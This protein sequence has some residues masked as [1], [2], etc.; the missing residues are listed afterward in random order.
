MKKIKN[1]MLTG[2]LLMVAIAGTS[3]IKAQQEAMTKQADG[4]YIV[5]TTTLCKDVKGYKS[6]TPLNI[7]IKS[8][9]IVKVEALRNQETPKY[10]VKVKKALLSQWDGKKVSKVAKF[11]PDAVTGATM[12]SKAVMENVKRGV[13]Y[14]QDNK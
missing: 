5:N 8:G 13:K 12:S 9:K 11:K 2:T 7:H 4:T 14:Y 3:A 10:F 1:V 6:T